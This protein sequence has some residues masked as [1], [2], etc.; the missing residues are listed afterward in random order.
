MRRYHP[1]AGG[2]AGIVAET[3]LR[4]E[5]EEGTEGETHLPQEAAARAVGCNDWRVWRSASAAKTSCK[6]TKASL[7]CAICGEREIGCLERGRVE[8]QARSVRRLE[9]HRRPVD[10]TWEHRCVAVALHGDCHAHLLLDALRALVGG[11]RHLAVELQV[12][13]AAEMV[14]LAAVRLEETLQEYRHD[15]QLPNGPQTA[16][17]DGSGVGEDRRPG[18]MFGG[19]GAGSA[20]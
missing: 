5:L 1:G 8:D 2:K 7:A 9:S 20:A 14:P 4:D 3:A 15:P 6:S 11:R 10:L 16:N 17:K 18:G 12:V 19:R 13:T